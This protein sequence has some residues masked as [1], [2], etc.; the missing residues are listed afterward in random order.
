[1]HM[2]KMKCS[3]FRKLPRLKRANASK[4][5]V[6]LGDAVHVVSRAKNGVLVSVTGVN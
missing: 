5:R 4:T 1:M 3:H 6:L 2:N